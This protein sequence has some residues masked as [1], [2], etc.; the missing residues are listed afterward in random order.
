MKNKEK[1]IQR[2]KKTCSLF[3]EWVMQIMIKKN[4][5][6]MNNT[7]FVPS[8]SECFFSPRKLK[9]EW[10]KEDYAASVYKECRIHCY[11]V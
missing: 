1:I 4:N 8:N 3:I 11:I 9:L 10:L 6:A 7:H 2:K 5:I